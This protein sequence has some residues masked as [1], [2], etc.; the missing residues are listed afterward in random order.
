MGIFR[1]GGS[2]D[3]VVVGGAVGLWC[4]DVL[5]W[6]EWVCLGGHRVGGGGPL[7]LRYVFVDGSER[8]V[9]MVFG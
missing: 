1:G 8:V 4:E 3:W 2:V 7:W 5:M 6:Y 9:S